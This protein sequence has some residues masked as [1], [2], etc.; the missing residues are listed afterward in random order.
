[1]LGKVAA[2]DNEIRAQTVAIAALV[3][4]PAEPIEEAVEAIVAIEAVVATKVQI[5]EVKDG[6]R[7]LR[8]HA[9]EEHSRPRAMCLGLD[10]EQA[11]SYRAADLARP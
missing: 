8:A 9:H 10:L 1:M 2:Q 4:V 6:D 7:V 3:E 5:G 11:R